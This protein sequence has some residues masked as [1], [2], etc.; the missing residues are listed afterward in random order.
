MIIWDQSLAGP[1]GLVA[2]YNLL[3]EHD[4]V[5]MYPLCGGSLTIPQNI[6][7][8][9][10]IT[11]PQLGLMD[12]IAENIHGYAHNKRYQFK[13]SISLQYHLLNLRSI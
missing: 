9:I 4:V 11:R 2:K 1:I 3:E 12:L 6:V 10:F 13:I 8:I 5:T 7:N